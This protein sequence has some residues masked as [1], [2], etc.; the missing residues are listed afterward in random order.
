MADIEI[1][2]P[3]IEQYA[4]EHTTP[5]PPWFA[6][7]AEETRT[8]TRAPGMMVGTLEGRLLA[9]FVAMLR[10]RRVLEI[11]TFTGYSAL[12]MAESLP[13]DGTIVTCDIS[14][15]HLSIARRHIA[16]SPYADRIEIRSGPA[17]DTIGTL[18]G[19]F[20]LVFID[21][22]KT[23]YQAYF[24][25]TLPKLAPEGVIAVDNVLWS[26]RPLDPAVSDPDTV[27]IREFNDAVVADD[28][29]EVVVLPV[30]DGVSLIRHRRA[31]PA[32]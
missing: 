26:G 8:G 22:N 15:E 10:P 23:G 5:E 7:L 29:I 4:L 1:V 3:R 11:G 13:P 18:P 6:T 9:A 19:P 31:A 27:A 32:A 2:D 20:D 21:A 25:A 17:L 12:S 28:R 16:A 24:E 30:R 14:E